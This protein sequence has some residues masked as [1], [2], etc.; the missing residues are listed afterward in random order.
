MAIDFNS[1]GNNL[2]PKARGA[3]SNV[4]PSKT[5]SS[6]TPTTAAATNSAPDRVELSAQAQNLYNTEIGSF[7]AA[8]VAALKGQIEAGTYK[9]YHQKL[10]ANIFNLE[11]KL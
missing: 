3:A 8:K 4:G 9:I 5:S 2:A 11:S 10:A 6:T 1:L 7:D